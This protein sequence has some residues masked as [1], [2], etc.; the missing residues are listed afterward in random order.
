[1]FRLANWTVNVYNEEPF[2]NCCETPCTEPI[3]TCSGT[4]CHIECIT[5]YLTEEK[6]YVIV[7]LI[8]QVGITQEYYATIELDTACGI[9]VIEHEADGWMG[10]C[11]EWNDTVPSS[12]NTFGDCGPLEKI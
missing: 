12:D 2:N 11:T 8:D 5:K 3:E 6:Y 9:T 4:T 7:N 1:M 10:Q